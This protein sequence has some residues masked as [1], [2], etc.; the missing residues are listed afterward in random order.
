LCQTP[1][2]P[3]SPRAKLPARAASTLA[4]M[5][6]AEVPVMMENGDRRGRPSQSLMASKAPT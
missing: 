6:P 5:A 4:L 2:R 3:S 1:A